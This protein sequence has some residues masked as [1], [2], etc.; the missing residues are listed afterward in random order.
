LIEEEHVRITK[1]GC[2]PRIKARIKPSKIGKLQRASPKK[3]S[4]YGP[5]KGAEL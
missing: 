4:S 3:F 2:K 1:A 5:T